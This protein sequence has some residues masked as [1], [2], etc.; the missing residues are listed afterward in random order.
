MKCHFCGREVSE[1]SFDEHVERCG[2][3]EAEWG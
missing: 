1:T 2:K 3:I